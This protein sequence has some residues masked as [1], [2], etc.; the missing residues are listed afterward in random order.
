MSSPNSPALRFSTE[1]IRLTFER[2]GTELTVEIDAFTERFIVAK[3]TQW[4]AFRKRLGQD[5]VPLSFREI[6]IAVDRFLSPIA[7]VF[8]SGK[9]GPAN[10]TAPGPWA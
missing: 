4:A 9:Q 2:R 8:S 3:Q 6:A 10:W 7:A 5:H 1:A